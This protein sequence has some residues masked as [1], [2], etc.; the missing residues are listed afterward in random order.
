M[1]KKLLSTMLAGAMAVSVLG[2]C[3]SSASTSTADSGTGTSAEEASSD[4]ETAV[5]TDA[6]GEIVIWVNEQMVTMTKT[7]AEGFLAEKGYNYSVTVEAVGVGDAAANMITD[8]VGGAD[9]YNFAQDQLARLVASGALQ[10]LNGTGYEEWVEEENG[11]GSVAAATFGSTVYAFPMSADNG[12]F[13]YYDSSVVTDTTSLEAILADCEAAGKNFYFEINNGWYQVAFFFGT[14]CTLTYETNDDGSFASCDIDYASDAGVVALKE[15]IELQS[16]SAFQNGSSL[17]S[18]TNVGAIVD[19]TW[20]SSA[21]QELFGDNYAA[22]K[23]PAFTGS[24]GETYQL[25]GFSGYKLLGVKP[26]TDA[27]K[28]KVCL[29]LAQYLT[30]EE[31]QL[32]RFEEAGWGPSNISVQASEAVQA[33]V[34]LSALAEQSNYCIGQGQY[35]DDYWTLA[36]ALGDDI[37]SGN[38]TSS[39]SDEDLMA[40]LEDFEAKCISY[41]K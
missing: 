6:S 4:T 28:L 30:G 18:A 23:L 33:D 7:A 12:Y 24:D 21:A 25:G 16:S 5:S 36:T 1:K 37:I 29:E 20:D 15:I 32:E 11:S 14:G 40:V 13:L 26:Q 8:V 17:S 38:I 10:P 31:C 27:D 41:A 34:A 35:P 39:T 9:L 22:A 19:G 3:G 2:G